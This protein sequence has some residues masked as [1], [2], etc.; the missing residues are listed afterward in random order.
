MIYGYARVSTTAQVDNTSLEAQELAIR[1]RFPEVTRIF[2]EKGVSGSI[3]LTDRP[4]GGELF[5][6][7]QP[8][9]V[10][11]ITKLDRAFRSLDDF[12]TM[13]RRFASVD[14]D[15]AILDLNGGQPMLNDRT[16]KFVL[17]M[18]AAVGELERAMISE[19]TIEGRRTRSEEGFYVGGRAPWGYKIEEDDKLTEEPWYRQA[20]AMIHDMRTDGKSAVQIKT[21]LFKE[22]GV[23]AS[24]PTILRIAAMPREM[25]LTD[26]GF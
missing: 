15:L 17:S 21:A 12:A 26:M 20:Y 8:K 6:L 7:L 18:F 25:Q 10:I 14:V 4:Q 2:V 3:P 24:P 13:A 9:D 1:K 5:R 11:V 23:N 22:L 19:R 16:G